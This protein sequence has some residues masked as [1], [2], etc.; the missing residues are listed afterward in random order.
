[1][2]NFSKTRIGKAVTAGLSAAI[3]WA[4]C[5]PLFDILF[6]GKIN[7]DTYKYVFEPIFIGIFLTIF[8]YFLFPPRDKKDKK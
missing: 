4:I 2:K 3:I 1:M 8:E 6:H 5:T 7:W